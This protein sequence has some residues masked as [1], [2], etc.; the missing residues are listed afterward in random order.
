MDVE[1]E[2]VKN[3]SRKRGG[4]RV[5]MEEKEKGRMNIIKEGGA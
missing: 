4:I 1:R 3:R 5:S 2:S